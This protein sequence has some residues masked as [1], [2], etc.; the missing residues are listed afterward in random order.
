MGRHTPRMSAGRGESES[1]LRSPDLRACTPTP[2]M[3]TSGQLTRSRR[4][5][6]KPFPVLG[7]YK[8]FTYWNCYLVLMDSEKF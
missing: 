4:I 1:G 6:E 5:A 8:E 2:R 3:K 7:L